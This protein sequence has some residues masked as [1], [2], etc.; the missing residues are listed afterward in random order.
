MLGQRGAATP[1]C[2]STHQRLPAML[3][4]DADRNS[5]TPGATTRIVETAEIVGGVSLI[6]IT[7]PAAEQMR[8]LLRE[9][10]EDVAVRIF[11]QPGQGNLVQYG[12]GFDNEIAEDDL[13]L[14]IAGIPFV[15][16][17]ESAPYV[18]GSEID[19]VDALM[20]RGFTL[21]NPNYVQGCGCG[22]GSCGCG[23]QH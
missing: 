4:R 2:P 17:Q 14:E 1:L 22:N 3:N 7:D 19:F 21:S 15:V 5:L 6:S 18:E 10:P 23:H 9:Q 8:D 16:D 12:M 20:G 13:V 11:A